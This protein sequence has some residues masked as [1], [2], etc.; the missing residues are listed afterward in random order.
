MVVRDFVHCI[1]IAIGKQPKRCMQSLITSSHKKDANKRKQTWKE[2]TYLAT[3]YPIHCA[4]QLIQNMIQ[5]HIQGRNIQ[6]VGTLYHICI[7]L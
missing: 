2:K 7:F 1:K 5:G 4:V 6:K 3:L